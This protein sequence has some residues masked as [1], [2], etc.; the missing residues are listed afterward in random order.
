VLL[1]EV[2]QLVVISSQW[3]AATRPS[4]YT[5][6]YVVILTPLSTMGH[7]SVA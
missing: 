7:T 6:T 5:H 3:T 4:L 2:E 1:L